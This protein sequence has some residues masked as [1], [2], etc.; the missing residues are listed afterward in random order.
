MNT[1]QFFKNTALLLL[2][3]IPLL[4]QKEVKAQGASCETARILMDTSSNIAAKNGDNWYVFTPTQAQKGTYR[5]Q[6]NDNMPIYV[7]NTCN[8]E[9]FTYLNSG[10]LFYAEAEKTYYF[11]YYN[12]SGTNQIWQLSRVPNV[13]GLLCQTPIEIPALSNAIAANFATKQTSRFWYRFTPSTAGYYRASNCGKTGTR[14]SIDIQSGNCD[15]LVY[16][17]TGNMCEYHWKSDVLF[18]GEAGKPYLIYINQ[19]QNPYEYPADYTWELRKEDSPEGLS[20][21]TPIE[22]ASTSNNIPANHATKQVK[23]LWYK[24]TPT[25]SGV[26]TASSCG[27][28]DYTSMSVYDSCGQYTTEEAICATSFNAQAGKTYYIVNRGSGDYTWSLHLGNNPEGLICQS[29]IVLTDTSNNILA[30]HTDKQSPVLWYRFAPTAA[31]EGEYS[32]TNCGKTSDTTQVFIYEGISCD[33]KT[34]KGSYT[35]TYCDI[36]YYTETSFYAEPG[37]TYYIQWLNQNGV[38]NYHWSFTKK[39]TRGK[40]CIT[41]VELKDTM[42]NIPI[43]RWYTFSPKQS[44]YYVASDYGKNAYNTHLTNVH[45]STGT[46]NELVSVGNI[47][48]KDEL[49][50]ASVFYAEVGKTY[51][52]NWI[53]YFIDSHWDLYQISNTEGLTCNSSIAISGVSDNI[54][55]DH[56]GKQSPILWYRF[57]PTESGEYI[58]SSCNKTTHKTYLTV[59]SGTCTDLSEISSSSNYCEN[60]SRIAF[61]AQANQT[62]YFRWINDDG[63]YSYNW[64]L[65]K[66]NDTEG[67]L[68]E[69]PIVLTDT[70]SN[71]KYLSNNPTL[72]YSFTP[73]AT[74]E[75]VY[76]ILESGGVY[77]ELYTGSCGNLN[78]VFNNKELV[79]LGTNIFYAEAGKT[80]YFNCEKQ[81]EGGLWGLSKVDNPEA[82]TC[83]TAKEV[84]NVTDDIS[85]INVG[86]NWFVFTPNTNQEGIYKIKWSRRELDY[87]VY[88]GSC[89]NLEKIIDRTEEPFYVEAGKTYYVKGFGGKMD[90]WSLVKETQTLEGKVCQTAIT[91]TYF[92]ESYI[93]SSYSKEESWYSFTPTKTAYYTVAS[94]CGSGVYDGECSTLNEIVNI[95]REP[96]NSISDIASKSTFYG[97]SGKTYYIHL[98][99][100]SEGFDAISGIFGSYPWLLLEESNPEFATTLSLEKHNLSLTLN[101]EQTLWY[102]ANGLYANPTWVSRNTAIAT[103][104]EGKVIAKAS[105]QTYI[106][107]SVNAGGTILKDSCLV[108]VTAINVNTNCQ[109]A[110]TITDTLNCAVSQTEQEVWYKFTPTAEQEGVYSIGGDIL[111][112]TGPCALVFE[113]FSGNCT[114]MSQITSTIC[115]YEPGDLGQAPFYAES[116]KTYYLKCEQAG[117]VS[118]ANKINYTWQLAKVNNPQFATAITMEDSRS[119]NVN[120]ECIVSCSVSDGVYY[121]PV[122]LS[123]NPDIAT[124]SETGKVTAK[125]PGQTYIVFSVNAGETILKDSCLVTVTEAFVKVS[126]IT[127]SA[128]SLAM[129]VDSVSMLTATV[130]PANATNKNISWASTNTGIA[131]VNNGVVTAKAIGT[132]YVIAT[133]QDGNFKD[134]CALTVTSNAIAVSGITLSAKNLALKVDSV[135]TLTATITPSNATNKNISWASTNTGIATVNNGVVTAKAIGTVYVIATTQDGNFK[136]TCAL[137]VTSNTIAVS[138]ITLSAQSLALK[139]DSVSTLTA[140][141]LPANATNKNISWASANTGIATVNNGAVKAKATGTA[142]IIATAEDGGYK[143]TCV[144]TVT[145]SQKE[146]VII[147]EVTSIVISWEKEQGAQN[148]VLIVYSDLARTQEVARFEFDASGNLLTKAPFTHTV[149]GLTS[150]TQ[151]Y[152]SLTAYNAEEEE[153]RT[154]EGGFTTLKTTGIEEADA[155]EATF[156]VYPNPTYSGKLTIESGELTAQQLNNSTI[157]LFDLVGKLVG[158]FAITGEKTEINIGHLPSGT[159]VVKV[160]TETV[161]VIK[162]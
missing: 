122:W 98:N 146:I 105:G 70:S 36:E 108:T 83:Q 50:I 73:T 61:T 34:S 44:G 67:R 78:N 119:L 114:K 127:L 102:S 140:T 59:F 1:K 107:F 137:T 18:Y 38:N 26:Y 109:A 84:T 13:E 79:S 149:T 14:S 101:E 81:M 52:I 24:F 141:V 35:N 42:S 40:Y 126:G 10:S 103:V 41:P 27:K 93:I 3:A 16:V 136:D 99:N 143:D 25:Q 22:I 150:E 110:I 82:L 100:L 156:V 131:T 60:Q 74:Q 96:F 43:N 134:T 57:T 4:W 117:I 147:P 112:M 76:K 104:S 123:R 162:K 144:V 63:S 58:V 120:G 94:P 53:S 12:I 151:Y 135:S 7:C 19:T 29:A 49:G 6:T 11:R 125:A 64:S 161:K 121:N 87:R 152:Y 45:I 157:Q 51:T 31:Q 23:E 95:S 115:L 124:V 39:D 77:V 65:S 160:G 71:I 86:Y 91:I 158:T 113:V 111:S 116:G 153:I 48:H 8:E 139:V 46:C 2:L 85:L 148:Y 133:T 5:V 33:D 56:A 154:F 54:A 88:T 15:S 92:G 68:C 9:S 90:T 69:T 128:K 32:L 55:A 72:W 47:M 21:Q 80:Y 129:K 66:N 130:L 75:G 20:C 28:S 62:Y 17:G 145:E 155:E 159:Y 138:S 132:V 89:N 37:K 142:Y 106:V 118:E 97:L 30:N